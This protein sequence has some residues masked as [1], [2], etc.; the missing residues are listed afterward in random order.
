M[1]KIKIEQKGK[2]KKK[3]KRG[4]TKGLTW[5]VFRPLSAVEERPLL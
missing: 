2:G 1:I 3:E 4:K 5:T